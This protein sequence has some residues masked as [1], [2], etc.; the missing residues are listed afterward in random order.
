[1]DISSW[2]IA[3][4]ISKLVFYFCLAGVI[5][6][7]SLY[8][9]TLSSRKLKESVA[10]YIIVAAVVGFMANVSSFYI[11]VGA[12]SESGLTGM[13]DG[14]FVSVLWSAGLGDAVASRAIGFTA[15][16]IAAV[17]YHRHLKDKRNST[18]QVV[19]IFTYALSLMAFGFS[20]TKI[21]HTVELSLLTKIAVIYHVILVLWWMGMLWPLYKACSMLASRELHTLMFRFGK[22]ASYAVSVLLAFGVVLAFSLFDSFEQVFFSAYGQVFL[23]K[24]ALVSGLLL[25]AANHKLRL[26]PALLK[27][28]AAH[29]KLAKSIQFEILIGVLV[30][31]ITTILTT[32]VGPTHA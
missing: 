8:C 28:A 19:A 1:M 27:N 22:S 10:K 29:R 25:I 30:L 20:F 2:I 16:L 21:G 9:V 26:V 4:S 5:G 31:T 18:A 32:Y 13:F 17:A 11:Q 7:G 14:M 12:I 23:M 24:I 6:G 3:T 15:I